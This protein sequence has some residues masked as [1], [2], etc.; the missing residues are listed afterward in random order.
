MAGQLTQILDYAPDGITVLYS[1]SYS[2]DVAGQLT[3]STVLPSSQTATSNASQTFDIDDKLASRNSSSAS[4]DSD[5]NLLSA[6]SGVTP[7]SFTYDARNR[8]TAA[9]SLSYGYNSENRRISLTDGSGTTLFVVNPNAVLDQVLVNTPSGGTPTYYVYGLGLLYEEKSS[10]PRYYH[11]DRRGDT[12]ALSNSSGAITTT[13][14]YG[15]YGELL[16]QTGS[17]ATPFECNGQWGVQTDSNGI[18]FNRAR[19]YSPELQRWLNADPIGL[20]G[21]LNLYAYVGND[22]I[23]YTDPLGLIS[24]QLTLG[25]SGTLGSMFGVSP[26]P[27]GHGEANVGISIDF[28]HPIDGSRYIFNYQGAAM[29][30][31]GIAAVGGPQVGLAL[32][33][34]SIPAGKSGDITVHAEA[35]ASD[36]SGVGGAIDINQNVIAAARLTNE[37]GVGIYGAGGVAATTTYGSPSIGEIAQKIADW[38]EGIAFGPEKSACPN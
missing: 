34:E 12:I 20:A 18:Y 13:L 28:S 10:A 5:G 16:G 21:G 4:F 17:L 3:G 36:I 37:Y 30:G 29:A 35:G 14:V 11:F 27:F 22:P 38:I 23:D 32:T 25:I 24:L 2:Y 9:G 7:A 8:L 19:Y 1:A 26:G 15:A 31:I 33:R 6:P